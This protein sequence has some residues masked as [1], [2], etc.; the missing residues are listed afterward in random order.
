MP[1]IDWVAVMN[2]SSRGVVFAVSVT[3]PSTLL[4]L[5]VVPSIICENTL[6]APLALVGQPSHPEW[7]RSRYM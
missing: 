3:K 5:A 6:T 1:L 2:G 4:R 7:P